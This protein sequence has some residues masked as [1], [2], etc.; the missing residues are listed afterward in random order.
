MFDARKQLSFKP[1]TKFS[2]ATYSRC[3]PHAQVQ[4]EE[5]GQQNAQREKDAQEHALLVAAE[6][7]CQAVALSR[8][9]VGGHIGNA[10]VHPMINNAGNDAAGAPVHPAQQQPHEEGMQHLCWIEMGQREQ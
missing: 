8:Q 10:V 3:F 6:D 1:L 9:Q 2:S 4:L 5:G 7:F